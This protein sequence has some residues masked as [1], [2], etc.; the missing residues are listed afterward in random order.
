MELRELMKL[1]GNF[2]PDQVDALAAMAL[3]IATIRSESWTGEVSFSLNVSEGALIDVHV[4][5][6]EVMRIGAK[7]RGVRG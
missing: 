7:K 1:L 3:K 6:R 5:R 2:A 4:N